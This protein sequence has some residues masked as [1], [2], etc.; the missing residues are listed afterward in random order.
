MMIYKVIPGVIGAIVT[1]IIFA[2]F[3]YFQ[4]TVIRIPVPKNAVIAF[5]TAS[6]PDGWAPYVLAEG[7]YVV[8]LV[9]TVPFKLRLASP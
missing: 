4:K 7:R 8:G 9:K 2:V 3:G 6:C 5:S 1:A